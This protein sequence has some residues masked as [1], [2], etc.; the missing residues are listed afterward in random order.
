[1]TAAQAAATEL[2]AMTYRVLDTVEVLDAAVCSGD[3]LTAR[4]AA[5]TLSELS[6]RIETALL[7]GE[8]DAK[9]LRLTAVPEPDHPEAAGGPSWR[10]KWVTAMRS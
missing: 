8:R 3:T 9:A 6:D 1:M 5:A 2:A 7:A 10:D 4:Y